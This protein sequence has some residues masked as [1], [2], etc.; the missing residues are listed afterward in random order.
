MKPGDLVHVTSWWD[1][2]S[3]WS[4]RTDVPADDMRLRPVRTNHVMLLVELDPRELE[5]GHTHYHMVF[6]DGIYGYIREDALESIR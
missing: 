6:F 5:F 2:V 4:G 3:L 1:G